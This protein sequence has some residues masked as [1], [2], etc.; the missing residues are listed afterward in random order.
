MP[1]APESQFIND[2]VVA[3]RDNSAGFLSPTEYREG[4]S[5]LAN[6]LPVPDFLCE[7]TELE[8]K[9]VPALLISPPQ[10]SSAV[11]MWYH[12]G[13][14]VIG[15]VAESLSPVDALAAAL[16]CHIISVD[17]RLAPENRF[18]AAYDDCVT[19]FEWVRQ[20][21]ADYGIDPLRISVGGDSAGGNLAA[22]VAQ[23]FGSLVR[24]QLLVYPVTSVARHSDSARQYHEGYFLDTP[25]MDWFIDQYTDAGQRTDPRVSPLQADEFTLAQVAR[26][27]VV[28]AEYDPLRD[29]GFDY[30]TRLRELDVPVTVD[31]HD[32][33]THGFFSIPHAI[34]GA[35]VARDRAVAALRDYL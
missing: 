34:P 7:Q 35:V 10:A 26:A 19:A 27:H 4:M 6:A 23:K 14:W 12:G 17:Y 28:I 2:I 21:G 8:L 29:D 13:G 32:D 24:T 22:A 30:A 16:G 25:L 18:P 15:S 31:H 1:L 9:G 33:Q 3:N 11:M 20:H 5:A